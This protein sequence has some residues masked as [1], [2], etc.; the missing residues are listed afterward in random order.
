MY[1]IQ[2]YKKQLI[3]CL[4]R[5]GNTEQYYVKG[6]LP[7]CIQLIGVKELTHHYCLQIHSLVYFATAHQGDMAYGDGGLAKRSGADQSLVFFRS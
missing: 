3:R 1:C 7:E 4:Y 6:K 5:S 2:R